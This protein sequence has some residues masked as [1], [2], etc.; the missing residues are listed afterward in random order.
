MGVKQA[1]KTETGSAIPLHSI[2][3]MSGC[4]FKYN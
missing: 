4:S 2:N 3:T 1:S